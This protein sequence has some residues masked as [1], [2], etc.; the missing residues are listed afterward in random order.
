MTIFTDR[1]ETEGKIG[2]GKM[3]NETHDVLNKLSKE[4][5]K[6]V[7][8]TN[9][10][11]YHEWYLELKPKVKNYIKDLKQS[12]F[13][14]DL[15]DGDRCKYI[16]IEEMDEIYYSNPK[17]IKNKNLYGGAGNYAIHNDCV[18]HFPGIK[19]YRVLIGLTDNNDNIT[20]YFTNFQK[21]HKL[22]KNDYIIF[23]FDNTTHQVIKKDENKRT[24]RILLKLHYLVCTGDGCSES[25][26]ETV[27]S[28][29]ILYETVTRY[30]MQLGSDPKTFIEF[31]VGLADQGIHSIYYHKIT[32]LYLLVLLFFVFLIVKYY[33]RIKIKYK[34]SWKIM[35]S[36]FLILSVIYLFVVFLFWTRYKLFGIK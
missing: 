4:W 36:S 27:K 23:D 15:C 11:V 34:N 21:G 6:E 17:K 14:H 12:K 24:P 2:I 5:K 8:D 7:P 16:N 19:L 35:K 26:M 18:F 3:P 29:Y 33:F 13:W 20:T 1:S 30:F 10:P 25:Y 31:F 9:M 28:L 32:K 22:N